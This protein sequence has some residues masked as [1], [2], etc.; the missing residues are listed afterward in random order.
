M[1]LEGKG[2]FIWKIKNCEGGDA[3]KIAQ[4]A[5]SAGFSHVLIKV[6]NGI[7]TYNYDWDRN[8]DLVP[9]VANALRSVG[10]QVWGWHYVYGESPSKEANKAVERVQ[11][12]NL[13]GFVVDAEAPY[14]KPN[15]APAAKTYMRKLRA[16]VG[17]NFPLA[18]S[19]YRFPSLH[20]IPW[21]EFLE[22]CD[23][24]MPQVYWIGAHNPGSQLSR[25]LEEFDSSQLKYHPPI[26]P[27]G[28]AFT[29][30]GWSPTAAEVQ[31]FLVTARSFNLSA[32]NFWEWHNCRDLL[33]PR[34][35]IWNTISSYDWGGP[36]P[37]QDITA[38]YVAALNSHNPDQVMNLYTD[39]AVHVTGART[40]VGKEKI[41][42]WYRTFF[43]EIL[44]NASFVLTGTSGGGN[45]RH[46]TWTA[47]SSN[48]K[49]NNG[50]DT[51]GLQD[52]KIVYHYTF[53][54][55]VP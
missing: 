4:V 26:I 39:R 55:V 44:P 14:K 46:H 53:F 48:G 5:K 15:K 49:V 20:R 51:L 3:N 38:R 10:I 41:E 47:Q 30:H 24:N 6:A 17:D 9:P 32:A 34:H 25:T 18:L 36:Q 13:D 35:K 19:S 28:A 50:S 8:V 7:Y 23:Y 29:E 33:T 11:G 52:G 40:I 21:N 1:T 27:T 22:K 42:A 31:E 54:T 45:N 16:G 37:P 12:L 43:N 2:F